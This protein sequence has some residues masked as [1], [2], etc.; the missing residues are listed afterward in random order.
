MPVC[1]I[2]AYEDF[3]DI[4]NH[5]T[6]EGQMCCYAKARII[7]PQEQKVWAIIGNTDGFR[8]I[9]NGENVLEKDEIGLWTP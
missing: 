7:S 4:D 9:I 1:T 8:L 2:E 6:L 5:F 3:I